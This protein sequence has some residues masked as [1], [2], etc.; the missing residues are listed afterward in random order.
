MGLKAVGTSDVL[1]AVF[2]AFNPYFLKCDMLLT[3]DSPVIVLPYFPVFEL[4]YHWEVT[5][6]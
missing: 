3:I 6:G 5:D 4:R 2:P 1:K